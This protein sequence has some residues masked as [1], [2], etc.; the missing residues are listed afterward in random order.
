MQIQSLKVVDLFHSL[1]YD[2]D[3]SELYSYDE[4]RFSYIYGEN[5]SGKTTILRLLFCALNPS[6][7]RG[8]RTYI[9]NVPFRSF[10]INLSSG[11]QISFHRD[12]ENVESP[13]YNIK[14]GR[15]QQY[16]V[17]SVVAEDDGSVRDKRNQEIRLYESFLSDL[18]FPIVFV[19]DDR[20]IRSTL[21]FI[22]D[23]YNG[24]VDEH[25]IVYRRWRMGDAGH[26]VDDISNSAIDA[27]HLDIEPLLQRAFEW[28]RA[29]AVRRSSTGDEN[30]NNIY[31]QVINRLA[32]PTVGA[33]PES[34]RTEIASKLEA[35]DELVGGYVDY[36]LVSRFPLMQFLD[37]IQE[38][39]AQTISTIKQVLFP[40]IETIEARLSALSPLKR[41]ISAFEDGLNHF[42]RKKRVSLSIVDRVSILDV[43]NDVVP[44]RFLSSG[45]KQLTLLFTVALLMSQ[46]PGLVLIDEPELSL[47]VR[48]QREIFDY[49]SNVCSEVPTQFLIASHSVEMLAKN[50]DS[51]IKL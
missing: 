46:R 33:Q 44:L 49:M 1:T 41:T 42:L 11:H 20:R 35:L 21:E 7:T 38:A 14:F 15:D 47:N 43:R 50:V 36:G 2:L 19:P 23:L 18:D 37:A 16:D 17:I 30:A 5:G 29:S 25:S 45:E 9:A 40:Y 26:I 31:V 51:T 39:P 4:S 32:H 10:E 3:F 22:D 6:P 27:H 24:D 28:V 8:Y 48:W 12:K 13:G 34:E